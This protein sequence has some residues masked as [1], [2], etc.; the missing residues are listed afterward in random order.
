[1]TEQIN[2][3]SYYNARGYE[4]AD[5][6]ESF[7]LNFNVGNVIKYVVRA[8][9]KPGE[10]R[11]EALLKAQVYLMREVIRVGHEQSQKGELGNDTVE[12]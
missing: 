11:V 8:G 6:I 1:M 3:P 7:G 9:H 12:L 4:V 10:D 2:H 5:F